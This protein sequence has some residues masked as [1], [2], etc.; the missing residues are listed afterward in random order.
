MY[1][2]LILAGVLA[3]AATA[4][5]DGPLTGDANLDGRVDDYDLSILLAHWGQDITADIYSLSDQWH[6]GEFNG[7]APVEDSDLSLLLANW[8]VAGA[9]PEPACA[10][11]LLLGFVGAALRRGRK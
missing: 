6:R 1:K 4:V 9:V 3:V 5:G 11:V 10:F 2:I 7:I 8:T